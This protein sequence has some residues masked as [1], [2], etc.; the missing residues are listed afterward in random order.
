M[1]KKLD[2][3][4]IKKILIVVMLLGICILIF[5]RGFANLVPTRSI[6][7]YSEKSSYQNS[8]GASF[9]IVKS[10]EWTEKNKAR[11]V[12]DLD[13][14]V[15]QDKK[16]KNII[17]VLDS[18]GT[19]YGEKLDRVKRDTKELVT[20]VLSNTKNKIGLINFGSD[21]TKLSDLTNDKDLLLKKITNIQSD[22]DTNYYQAL[23]KV[24]EILKNYK[25]QNKEDVTVLFLT[26]GFA[27][28]QTPNEVGEYQYLKE[29]YDYLTINGIQYEMGNFIPD[30]IKNISDKQFIANMDSLNNILFE[31]SDINYSYD[32]FVITDYIDNTYFTISDKTKIKTTYGTADLVLENSKQKVVWNMGDN[33]KTG[34]S[35]KLIIDVDLNNKYFDKGGYYPTNT[36][37]TVK[38]TI[39]GKGE[40]IISYKTPVL[41]NKNKVIYDINEPSGCSV[42][43]TFKDEDHLV[44]DKV[45]ISDEVPSCGGYY[46]RG[47]KVV[48]KNVKGVTDK[49]FIMPDE[50]VIIRGAWSKVQIIKSMDGKVNTKKDA[51]IQARVDNSKIWKYNSSISKINF[52]NTI[53]KPENSV[54]EFDLS[55][56]NTGTVM[57]YL[58]TDTNDSSKYVLYI[59]ANGNILANEDSSNWFG[60]FTSLNEIVGLEYFDTSNVRLM[61]SMFYYCYSLKSLDIS[62]F[63]TSNVID[64]SSMFYN[65]TYIKE[66]DL[67]NWNTSKVTSMGGMF[68]YCSLVKSVSLSGLDLSN[69]INMNDM[70]AY[71]GCLKNV[72]F[73]GVN[74]SNLRDMSG[75]FYNCS[76]EEVDLS[77]L[78][79]SKVTNMN[80][81]FKECTSLVKLN[82]T[83]WN[84]TSVTYMNSMFYNCYSLVS[85]DLGSFVTSSV[86][87]M[88]SM[89]YN[90]SKL[91]TLN[92]SNFDTK[93]V[94]NF[95]K[96]FYY[97]NKLINVDVSKFNTSKATTMWQM[98][99]ACYS[100]EKL[101][102]SNFDTSNVTTFDSMFG[103]CSRLKQLDVSKF[104]TSKATNFSNMFANCSS[105]TSLDVSHF[106]TSNAI[107]LSSIFAN[108]VGLTTIDVS[109][110]N[111]SKVMNMS[112]MFGGC[113][114]LITL[115]I[116][117][118]DTKSVQYM[119]L[120]FSGL[121]LKSLDISNI[122][123]SN[124]INMS[125]LFSGCSA[126]TS[127][128]L[129]NITT[130]KVVDINGMFD[131][132]SSLTSLDI[133]KFNT[134]KAT[135]ISNLFRNCK[136]LTSLNLKNFDTSQVTNMSGLFSGCSSLTSIDVSKFNTSKVINM[137]AMFSGCEALSKLDVSNF[138]TSKVVNM[139]SLFS[140]CSGLTNLN[141]SNFNTS[142][143]TNISK[144]FEGCSALT[145]L[146]ITNFN[147]S[148]VTDM[149]SLFSM[150]SSLTYLDLSKLNTAS[151]RNMEKM[152]YGCGK[153]STEFTIRRSLSNYNYIFY[154]AAVEKGTMITVNYTSAVSR[155]IDDI[156]FYGQ[157][158]N[159]YVY[160]GELVS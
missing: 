55:D 144:M 159:S 142:K 97:C 126:L 37:E 115:D 72:D 114:G 111:T 123:T 8:E 47:F 118:F 4:I 20:S 101:D 127:I 86:T 80:S 30:S 94:N 78:D 21:A 24:D 109:N 145:S 140:Y 121:T 17:L 132:C 15:M 6:E 38:N 58:V 75:M 48:N 16:N 32:N 23:I 36:K 136:L 104:N 12:F 59:Q 108:C 46:F 35:A 112:S 64:M 42:Q 60:G 113:S 151:T 158:D 143:V 27:N 141:V 155:Y 28:M 95:S 13:T 138:D 31:S 122:D 119:S 160:I 7:I 45:E 89:F 5:K 98:F 57:A 52:E 105:L 149:S 134:S 40:D 61:G 153:L 22:G 76:I 110:F 96:T 148:L 81:M 3:N 54:Y 133:S 147:T 77:S 69:V 2:F 10:A 50:D 9:K 156:I 1:I 154:D 11:I 107:S 100:L 157:K 29:K 87:D 44:Y 93:N 146:D 79:T 116:K 65:C 106:D 130:A 128:D 34:N 19:M 131:G 74:T 51:T 84:T 102:V 120:M 70:F 41:S 68:Y 137:S 125:G 43:E 152:F 26:D 129:S 18:S 82:V 71:C 73:S 91:S 49:S 25:N 63:D 14:K 39:N 139:S 90:C 33:F 92:I 88:N 150:C 53:N 135:N 124:V 103:G 67:S 85:L 56:D 66:F 117:N 83:G 62:H 99:Y